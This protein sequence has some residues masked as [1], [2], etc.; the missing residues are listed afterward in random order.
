MDKFTISE[1]NKKM[2]EKMEKARFVGIPLETVDCY[3]CPEGEK[4]LLNKKF[5][6]SKFPCCSICRP[7]IN[8]SVRK[9]GSII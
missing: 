3:F 9:N 8:L 2:L 1:H 5:A 4:N 7:K 6:T